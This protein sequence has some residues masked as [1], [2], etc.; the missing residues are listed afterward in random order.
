MSNA[1]DDF[2]AWY[3][4]MQS[5]ERRQETEAGQAEVRRNIG[6]AARIIS[7]LRHGRISHDEAV[8]RAKELQ[9]KGSLTK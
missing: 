5:P 6:E 9:D 8:R 4:S 3:D 1:F 7:D 2:K